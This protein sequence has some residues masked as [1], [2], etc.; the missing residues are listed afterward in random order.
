[1]SFSHQ[2]DAGPGEPLNAA[3]AAHFERMRQA[4]EVLGECEFVLYLHEENGKHAQ[5]AIRFGSQRD[6]AKVAAALGIGPTMVRPLGGQG[7][8]GRYLDYLHHE[9]TYLPVVAN[10]E[11]RAVMAAALGERKRL[12]VS[13]IERGLYDGDLTIGHVADEY[14]DEFLRH[15][16]KFV[17]AYELGEQRRREQRQLTQDERDLAEF[18]RRAA[19]RARQEEI[20]RIEYDRLLA[21]ADA[22]R[23]HDDAHQWHST[24]LWLS[25]ESAWNATPEGAEYREAVA[26]RRREQAEQAA[27]AEQARRDEFDLRWG[28]AFLCEDQC[29]EGTESQC[30]AALTRLMGAPPTLDSVIA[31]VIEENN[32]TPESVREEFRLHYQDIQQTWQSALW[33]LSHATDGEEESIAWLR[34]YYAHAR[35]WPDFYNPMMPPKPNR[36]TCAGWAKIRAELLAVW[37]GTA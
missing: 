12:T 16:Q 26:Q 33:H 1:M 18:E 4:P 23:R 19:E 10:F 15:H 9:R 22:E 17:K 6:L 28:I 14:T 2:Y 3:D 34:R 25:M 11:W 20:A 32:G 8:F 29:I 36:G 13:A 5:G 37:N 27:A 35:R 24:R 7:N 30:T 21:V 31:M